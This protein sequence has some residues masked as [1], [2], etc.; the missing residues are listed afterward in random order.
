MSRTAH[1]NYIHRFSEEEVDALNKVL[2][3]TLAEYGETEEEKKEI[4]AEFSA[5]LK[6]LR[7]LMDGTNRKLRDGYE[8]RSGECSVTRDTRSQRVLYHLLETGDLVKERDFEGKDF[9]LAIDDG[10]YD[11]RDYDGPPPPADDEEDDEGEVEA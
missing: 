9:Q 10:L 6:K 7:G 2:S 8:E 4:A 1:V 11:G 5:K 3:D